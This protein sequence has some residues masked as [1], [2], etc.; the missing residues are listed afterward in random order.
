[1]TIKWNKVKGCDEYEIYSSTKEKEGYKKLKK[2]KSSQTSLEIGK[3]NDKAV[4]S[5][6]TYYFYIVGIKNVKGKKYTSGKHYTQE[7]K[8]GYVTNKW[9]F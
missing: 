2:V 1:M 6:N 5:K 7:V 8:K 4:S 9:T 3:N